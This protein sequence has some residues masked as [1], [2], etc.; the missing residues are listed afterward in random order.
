[1]GSTSPLACDT[2][3]CKG[4]WEI[5][6]YHRDLYQYSE[7]TTNDVYLDR[8]RMILRQLYTDLDYNDEW[9]Q[10]V[11]SSNG[12]AHK[13]RWHP[14][15]SSIYHRQ[16]RSPWYLLNKK[17]R[18]VGIDFGT[19]NITRYIEY[20][21]RSSSTSYDYIILLTIDWNGSINRERGLSEIQ[22]RTTV[23]LWLTVVS[24]EIW[25]GRRLHTEWQK[26]PF[27]GRKGQKKGLPALIK[28][29][30]TMVEPT[31]TLTLNVS[32]SFTETLTAVM[33]STRNIWTKGWWSR[34]G[35]KL[36]CHRANGRK[37]DKPHPLF[38][39]CR[40]DFVH[41][42]HQQINSDSHSL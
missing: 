40:G 8:T 6:P 41:C 14:R 33:H 7:K 16:R 22:A 18:M 3:N 28:Q 23:N 32:S 10:P 17:V 38:A 39:D 34:R 20:L 5:R 4:V 30:L 25:N 2:T 36:T 24:F 26:G 21:F 42:F 19:R 9:V 1:M 27:A 11:I 29:A 13:L 35:S 12:N 15:A 37:H 31:A